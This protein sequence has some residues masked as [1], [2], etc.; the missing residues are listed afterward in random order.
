M[1]LY[2]DYANLRMLS[3]TLKT[4]GYESR[5]LTRSLEDELDLSDADFIYIGSG[6]ESAAKRALAHLLS[7]KAAFIEAFQRGT[8]ILLTGNAMEL[9]GR[10]IVSKDGTIYEG[11]GLAPFKTKE[12][13]ARLVSDEIVSWEGHQLVG[14]INKASQ[15][16]GVDRPLFR[17]DFG[18]GNSEGDRSE[19]W[20]ENNLFATHLIG[21]I[22][23]K[24]PA[25]LLKMASLAAGGALLDPDQIINPLAA[26]AYRNSLTE[27]L[28][29]AKSEGKG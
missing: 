2:G 4:A 25:F 15:I 12:G 7:Q 26:E 16:T 13:N 14:F 8:P 10:Q 5:I 11:L 20:T 1:D 22:L 17:V 23:V 28:K 29:R 18:L 3:L 27:L 21:P 19:G 9:I 24:N 6:K